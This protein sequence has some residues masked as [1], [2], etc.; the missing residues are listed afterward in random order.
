MLLIVLSLIEFIRKLLW[1]FYIKKDVNKNIYKTM[2]HSIDAYL[3]Q[4]SLLII[5]I[6]L[7]LLNVVI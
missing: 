5:Y 4:I 1:R 7:K 2:Q 6:D 3:V